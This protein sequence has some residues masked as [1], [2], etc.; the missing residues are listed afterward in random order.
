MDFQIW[1]ASNMIFTHCP[2]DECDEKYESFMFENTN[3]S[4]DDG[5]HEVFDHQK[6]ANLKESE[7][8]YGRINLNMTCKAES[9]TEQKDTSVTSSIFSTV[10]NNIQTDVSILK[11]PKTPYQIELSNKKLYQ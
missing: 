7:Q 6:C 3:E 11:C 9:E 8:K 1:R 10:E 4:W 2:Y 5:W